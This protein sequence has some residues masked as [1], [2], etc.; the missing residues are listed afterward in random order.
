M[1]K[2]A[3]LVWDLAQVKGE[4]DENLCNAGGFPV[5]LN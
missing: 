3:L 1:L 2:T 5:T 4:E